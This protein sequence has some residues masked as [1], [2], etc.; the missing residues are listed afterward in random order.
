MNVLD[1]AGLISCSFGA[2]DGV[3]G[4]TSASSVDEDGYR[5]ISLQFDGDV[6]VGALV[7]GRTDA[8]G[9]LR[10]LIQSKLPL[11]DWK[12]RL[13]ADPHR[14]QDAYVALTYK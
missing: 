12:A 9:V 10:G 1:T 2:W 6:L 3:D 5:Y 14:V 7:I 13:E 11:G 4:G 8:I